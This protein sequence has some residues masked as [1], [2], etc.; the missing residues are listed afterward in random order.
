MRPLNPGI[1]LN[2]LVTGTVYKGGSAVPA[3]ER[4]LAEMN[5][6]VDSACPAGPNRAEATGQKKLT[7]RGV[8][9]AN[10]MRGGAPRTCT[11]GEHARIGDTVDYCMC[12]GSSRHMVYCLLCA[13]LR[14]EQRKLVRGHKRRF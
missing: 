5:A 2:M 10:R 12:D 14:A 1:H 4:G 3:G 9:N 7:R 6:K 8:D 13:L 11:K